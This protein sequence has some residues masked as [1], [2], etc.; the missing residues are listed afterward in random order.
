MAPAAASD[1]SLS[2]L[3]ATA[4]ESVS[5]VLL[6][7]TASTDAIRWAHRSG[8][9]VETVPGHEGVPLVDPD[10]GALV[11]HGVPDVFGRV[12]DPP[13][14]WHTLVVRHRITGG[15]VPAFP[16][17]LDVGVASPHPPEIIA[18]GLRDLHKRL[19]QQRGVRP[20]FASPPAFGLPYIAPG[21]IALE[22][23]FGRIERPP[24]P[25]LPEL[26]VVRPDGDPTHP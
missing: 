5:R 25:G 17:C 26:V 8:L 3:T 19:L 2:P 16:L 6:V 9:P 4:V 22:G 15:S 20:V 1:A 12:L 24:V 11:V 10:P 14:G 7:A 21:G 13:S 18:Q 23:R